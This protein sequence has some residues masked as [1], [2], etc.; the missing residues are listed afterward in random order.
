MLHPSA[1]GLRVVAID[2]PGPD[3]ALSRDAFMAVKLAHIRRE[4]PEARILVLVGNIH[5]MKSMTW[6][7][8]ETARFIPAY[9]QRTL[10]GV[11]TVSVHQCVRSDMPDDLRGVLGPLHSPEARPQAYSARH[12]ELRHLQDDTLAV[13]NLAPGL[14]LADEMDAVIYFPDP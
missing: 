10:P 2:V 1:G 3:A 4:Q 9:L 13:V 6:A 5:A 14:S 7:N 8:G 12:P 11:R